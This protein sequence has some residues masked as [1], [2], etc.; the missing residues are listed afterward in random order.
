MIA[1]IAEKVSLLVSGG[2]VPSR[3]S[4]P[5]VIRDALITPSILAISSMLIN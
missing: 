5:L 1:D 2:I 3:Y 4:P